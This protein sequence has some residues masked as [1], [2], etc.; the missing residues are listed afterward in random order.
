MLLSHAPI[1]ATAIGR[2]VMGGSAVGLGRLV[3]LR[4]GRIAKTPGG[5]ALISIGARVLWRNRSCER[6]P[7]HAKGPG[8]PGPSL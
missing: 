5:V 4:F 7:R 2:S 8:N 1:M 3:G 6:R